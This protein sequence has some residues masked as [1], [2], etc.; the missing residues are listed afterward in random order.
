[1]S[2]FEFILDA[3]VDPVVVVVVVLSVVVVPVIRDAAFPHFGAAIFHL[4]VVIS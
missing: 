1:M 2:Y 4:D 3:G